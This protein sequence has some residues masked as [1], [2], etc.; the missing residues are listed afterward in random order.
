MLK[1]PR[2]F[3]LILGIFIFMGFFGK[4][5]EKTKDTGSR[6]VK[7]EVNKN[8]VETGEIF[9]YSITVEGEFENPNLQIPN[10]DNFRIVSTKKTKNFL[11][12]KNKVKAQLNI[13]YFLLCPQPGSFIIKPVKIT[14]KNKTYKSNSVDIIAKGEPLDKKE[15]LQPYIESGI[16]I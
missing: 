9:S 11:Y 15:Q 8:K 14:E 4:D 5:S 13:T 7:V 6:S 2:I 16:E 1:L 3:I 12:Q 10:L